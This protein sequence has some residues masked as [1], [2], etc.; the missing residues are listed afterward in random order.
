MNRDKLNEVS[1]KT[2]SLLVDMTRFN[3]VHQLGAYEQEALMSWMQ[4]LERIRD[5]LWQEM[6]QHQKTGKGAV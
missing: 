4:R 1:F 3:S 2:D 5:T 6:A